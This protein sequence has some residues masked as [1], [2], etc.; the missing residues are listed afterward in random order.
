[1][2]LAIINHELLG[3]RWKLCRMTNLPCGTPLSQAERNYFQ[4][5]SIIHYVAKEEQFPIVSRGKKL[6]NMEKLRLLKF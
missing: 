2:E 3:D 1:M 6:A 4:I 5:T